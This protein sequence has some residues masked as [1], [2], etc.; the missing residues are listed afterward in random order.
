MIII[1]KNIQL[2]SSILTAFK[3][4]QV[5]DHGKKL[6]FRACYVEHTIFLLAKENKQTNKKIII[7]LC[8]N[9]FNVHI[10]FTHSKNLH[11]CFFILRSH[12]DLFI[13]L[14]DI[15]CVQMNRHLCPFLIKPFHLQVKFCYLTLRYNNIIQSIPKPPPYLNTKNDS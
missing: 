9:I 10:A 13:F 2:I 3:V 12:E 14:M 8:L 1:K 5:V 6:N 15:C 7:P 4:N 11:E